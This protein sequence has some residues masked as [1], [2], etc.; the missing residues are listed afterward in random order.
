MNKARGSV[1]SGRIVVTN[2]EWLGLED[3]YL[4]IAF[5]LAYSQLAYY[6]DQ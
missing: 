1:I 5:G 2:A 3:P 4:A 6:A